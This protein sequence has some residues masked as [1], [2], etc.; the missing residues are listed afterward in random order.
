MPHHSHNLGCCPFTAWE[1]VH[2][3][4]MQ[5]L[6]TLQ[7]LLMPLTGV[8]PWPV[9]IYAPP[10][11]QGVVA[12]T[13]WSADQH[14]TCIL[15]THSQLNYLLINH[16]LPTARLLVR[17]EGPT[18]KTLTGWSSG[19]RV[20]TCT[21]VAHCEVFSSPHG[22]HGIHP[23]A[24]HSMGDFQ[25]EDMATYAKAMLHSLHYFFFGKIMTGVLGANSSLVCWNWL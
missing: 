19:R 24:D 13:G 11:Y 12:S 21:G 1:N 17:Q 4:M 10:H 20:P 14:S 18:G 15:N 22:I 3:G 25:P 2:Q 6:P 16:L 7:T 23:K 9:N 5:W 8:V